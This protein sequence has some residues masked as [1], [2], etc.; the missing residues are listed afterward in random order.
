MKFTEKVA[1]F[2]KET[3]EKLKKF[4]KVVIADKKKLTIAIA[5][6]AVLVIGL[7]IT[8]AV[9]LPREG[10]ATDGLMFTSIDDGK[11][12]SVSRGTAT[13]GVINIPSKYKGKPVT[14]IAPRGF[15]DELA[16]Y[17]TTSIVIP[18]SVTYIGSEAIA[19]CYS[20]TSVTMSANVTYI[21]KEAFAYCDNLQSIV[22]PNSV[23]YIG[24]DAFNG[25]GSLTSVAFGENSQLST[26]EDYTFA[27]CESLTNITIPS[28][29]TY[30]G[31]WAFS[32]CGSLTNIT[33]LRSSGITRLGSYVFSSCSSLTNIYVPAGG[34]VNAYKSASGWSSYASK[35]K[36]IA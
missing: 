11:A 19:Y 16:R 35:I 9:T 32:D 25:C 20:L 3:F 15:A 8:L 7:P 36:A 12:Y 17:F 31:D 30:I 22:I 27:N 29:V 21:G 13:D 33:L 14:Q 10:K 1:K 26:I 4:A 28:S 34:G 23:T 5:V 18:N 6:I 24:D 2:F